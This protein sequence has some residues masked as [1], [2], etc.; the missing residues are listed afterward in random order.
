[1]ARTQH[2]LLT[3]ILAIGTILPAVGKTQPKS[4]AATGAV[5]VMTNAAEHNEIITYKRGADGSLTEGRSFP[6]GGRGSGGQSMAG[7]AHG[8][9]D[10]CVG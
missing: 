1:M 6:T 9:N 8:G 2:L 10:D 4:N 5:F 7:G 3:A